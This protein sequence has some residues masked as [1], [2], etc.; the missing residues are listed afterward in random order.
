MPDICHLFV[1]ELR[2]TFS[3]RPSLLGVEPN[4]IDCYAICA[5]RRARCLYSERLRTQ[6]ESPNGHNRATEGWDYSIV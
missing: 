5:F 3:F 6:K 2:A 1:S 4:R